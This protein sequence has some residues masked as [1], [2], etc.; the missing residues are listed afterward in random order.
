MTAWQGGKGG[1]GRQRGR[2]QPRLS[3]LGPSQDDHF[4]LIFLPSSSSCSCLLPAFSHAAIGAC[5]NI[6]RERRGGEGRGGEQTLPITSAK[7]RLIDHAC[8]G[9]VERESAPLPPPPPQSMV[10]LNHGN[11][12]YLRLFEK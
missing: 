2:P 4:L 12:S 3:P 11:E 6:S 5:Q 8:D 9:R 10:K 7:S 1:G